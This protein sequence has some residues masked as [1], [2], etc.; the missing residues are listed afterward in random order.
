[1]KQRTG[2]FSAVGDDGC[3]YMVYILNDFIDVSS[4][5]ISGAVN[6]GMKELRTS[7]GMAVNRLQQG[8]YQV[9]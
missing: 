8:E 5:N 3:Q 7:D 4:H 9:V 1:M 2:T 6:R